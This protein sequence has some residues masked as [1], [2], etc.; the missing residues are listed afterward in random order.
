[1]REIFYRKYNQIQNNSVEMF[2]DDGRAHFICL[3]SSEKAEK[4]V[5]ELQQRR[6]SGVKVVKNA[7]G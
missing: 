4:I 3:Y 5:K 1:M 7:A 6:G 2:C